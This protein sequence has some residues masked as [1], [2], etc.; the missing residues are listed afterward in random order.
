[1]KTSES[2]K[3]II[4]ALLKVQNEVISFSKDGFNPHFKNNYITLDSI[5]ADDPQAKVACEVV[6]TTGLVLVMGE[7]VRPGAFIAP[8][9]ARILD[10]LAL[11]GGTKSNSGAQNIVLTRQGNSSEQ[12][13][14]TDYHTLVNAQQDANLLVQ[15]GDVIFVPEAKNQV[16]V[17]GEVT[18]P[19]VYSISD[20]AKV[21]DAIALAGGPKERAALESIGI[22][23]DGNLDESSTLAV[24]KDKLLFQGNANENPP[25]MGGDII[26][27]PETNKPNWTEIF[28]F[29]GGIRTFQQ[30]I[31][32][33]YNFFDN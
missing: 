1:M 16:L 28:G 18:R 2:I 20:G 31:D 4:P 10:L 27:V 5:L 11:A 15:G 13:W 30:I 9:G 21:L 3:Q 12:V 6:A 23:R 24:G 17:L 8:Q 19:G 33:F 32:W 14:V 26:Y 29:M 22:Y 7:V 25:I